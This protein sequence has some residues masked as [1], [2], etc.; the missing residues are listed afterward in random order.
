[1]KQL[2]DDRDPPCVHKEIKKLIHEKNQAYKLNL[3]NKNKT[4]SL[5]QFKFLK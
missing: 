1:M 2:P 5:H 4:F 3:Q